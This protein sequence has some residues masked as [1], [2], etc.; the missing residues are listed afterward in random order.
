MGVKASKLDKLNWVSLFL[1][2][3]HCSVASMAIK[4]Y[5]FIKFV[6]FMVFIKDVSFLCVPLGLNIQSVL[7]YR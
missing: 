6:M 5:Q 2:Y 3:V 7:Q 1:Y 4:F